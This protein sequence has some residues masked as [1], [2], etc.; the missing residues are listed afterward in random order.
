M[1]AFDFLSQQQ[2]VQLPDPVAGVGRA[3]TLATLARQN[4]RGAYEEE[5]QI[6]AQEE[7]EALRKALPTLLQGG[8]SREAVQQVIAADPRV[9]PSVLKFVDERAKADLDRRKTEADITDKTTQSGERRFNVRQKAFGDVGNVAF[10][11]MQKPGPMSVAKVMQVAKFYGI[12][13]DLAPPPD[14][15]AQ[16]GDW[17]SGIGN[18]AVAAKDRMAD[19]TTRARDTATDADRDASREQTMTIAGMTDRRARDFNAAQQANAA[20]VRDQAAA[21][22]DA[23][24]TTATAQSVSALRKEFNGLQEVQNYKAAAPVI[25]SARNA[26]DTP[27]GDLDLIYAVG[28]VLDP[29]SVVREGE[30]ALVIKSGS[31]M[32]RFEGAARYIMAGK[33]RLPP[34]QRAELLA[35]LN[36][37]TKQLEEGYKAS[38]ATYERAA[39]AGGLPKDQ[40]FSDVDAGVPKG[41][42]AGAAPAAGR[43]VESMPMPKSLAEGTRVKDNRTGQIMVVRGGKYVPE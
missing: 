16:V 2:G 39:D 10:A 33:G 30:M 36:G 34:G 32:Q 26:P 22:R 9:G 8:F 31:P 15:P 25:Q 3:L 41:P 35:L 7:N 21:T 13:K 19:T 17:L 42:A 28:K 1:G 11:E 23:A 20:A 18:A 29:N 27:A 5:Q 4:R 6:R 38:R 43:V 24:R 40:I 14:D 37:R 12:D